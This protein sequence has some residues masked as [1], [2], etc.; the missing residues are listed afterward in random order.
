ME[1]LAGYYSPNSVFSTLPKE[2]I[3]Y[4]LSLTKSFDYF[5]VL[6][7]ALG[8][9]DESTIYFASNFEYMYNAKGNKTK[10]CRIKPQEIDFLMVVCPKLRIELEIA[11]VEENKTYSIELII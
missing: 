4:I 9:N 2:L 7:R 5:H 11:Y 6:F 3:G 8:Y 10:M 1:L